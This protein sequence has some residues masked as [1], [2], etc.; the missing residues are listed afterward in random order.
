VGPVA[1]INEGIEIARHDYTGAAI[2][3][4]WSHG[5]ADKLL[6]FRSRDSS[7]S[8]SIF[9]RERLILNIAHLRYEFDWIA[10]LTPLPPAKGPELAVLPPSAAKRKPRAPAKNSGIAE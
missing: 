4:V 3:E 7:D 2:E 8:K 9:M 5:M 10:M 6:P 1:T